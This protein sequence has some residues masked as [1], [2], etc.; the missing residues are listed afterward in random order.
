M[1]PWGGVGEAGEGGT[2]LTSCTECAGMIHGRTEVDEATKAVVEAAKAV[3]GGNKILDLKRLECHC[4]LF[5]LF[6]YN[7]IFN[8][9]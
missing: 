6:Q 4:F 3:A 2:R 7:N 1:S 5:T 9:S 8:T